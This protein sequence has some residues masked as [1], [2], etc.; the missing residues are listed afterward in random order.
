MIIAAV[1]HFFAGA[2]AGS[3]FSVQILLVMVALVLIECVS[4]AAVLGLSS[5]FWALQLLVVIQLGYLA[6]IYFRSTV[7][8]RG[9]AVAKPRVQARHRSDR[10]T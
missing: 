2:I 5:G 7:E 10:A 1:L 6:G 4:V 3:V 9:S 8:A